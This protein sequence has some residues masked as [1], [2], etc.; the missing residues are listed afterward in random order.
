VKPI[1]TASELYD[2]L[3]MEDYYADEEKEKE[4]EWIEDINYQNI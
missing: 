2:A 4:E 1:L 3:E